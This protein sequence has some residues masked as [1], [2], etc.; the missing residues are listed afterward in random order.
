MSKPVTSWLKKKT[1]TRKSLGRGSRWQ[2]GTLAGIQNRDAQTSD[3]LVPGQGSPWTGAAGRTPG[4]LSGKPLLLPALRHL[5]EAST[6]RS[7]L[8]R[9]PSHCQRLQLPSLSDL[10]SPRVLCSALPN[11]L[12]VQTGP[13]DVPDHGGF[14]RSGLG[15]GVQGVAANQHDSA[16]GD[17]DGVEPSDLVHIHPATTGSTGHEGFPQQREAGRDQVLHHRP[18]R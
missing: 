4:C 9:A 2:K 8:L 16:E 10:W 5:Q 7:S 13:A 3:F 18:R 15:R 11:H 6:G 12:N 14:R 17:S 1:R